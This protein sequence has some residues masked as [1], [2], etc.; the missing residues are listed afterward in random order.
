MK[1]TSKQKRPR[2]IY[3]DCF[4]NERGQ[5]VKIRPVHENLLEKK[6]QYKVVS[7]DK[8]LGKL[9]DRLYR[10]MGPLA[11]VWS[12]IQTFITGRINTN[13]TVKNMCKT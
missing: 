6:G 11:K 3:R 5:T 12:D 7:I 2:P 13:L 4:S 8:E 10:V 1:Q 9:Q